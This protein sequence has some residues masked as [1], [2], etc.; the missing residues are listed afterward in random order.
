MDSKYTTTLKDYIK[1]KDIYKLTYSSFDL[2]DK[3]MDGEISP[4]RNI[5]HDYIDELQ[6]ASENLYLSDEEFIQYKYRPRLLANRIYGDPLYY[7]IILLI[8]N[9]SDEKQFTIN[10][11]KIIRPDLM[12]DVLSKIYN[13]NIETLKYYGKNGV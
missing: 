12:F 5:L 2:Y 9:M 4:T 8:N 3:S 10:P 1:S 13:S 11:I 7:Y 6:D